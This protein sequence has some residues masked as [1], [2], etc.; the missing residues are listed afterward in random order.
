MRTLLKLKAEAANVAP[1]LIANADDIERLAARED[2]GVAALHGW[3]AKVFGNDVK[4]LRAGKIALA[5]ENDEAVI[6]ELEDTND[7]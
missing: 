7:K 4:A 6:V 2:D 1:R 5:L 3:R